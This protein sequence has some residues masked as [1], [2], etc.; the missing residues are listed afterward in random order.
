MRE[1]ARQAPA[2]WA[3]QWEDKQDPVAEGRRGAV[4]AGAVLRA[5]TAVA[6]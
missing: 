3:L 6:G 1:S 2:P 5:R 4:L